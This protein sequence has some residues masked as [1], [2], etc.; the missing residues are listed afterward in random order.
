MDVLRRSNVPGPA[1]VGAGDDE[2][3]GDG[4]LEMDGGTSSERVDVIGNVPVGD[5]EYGVV[6]FGLNEK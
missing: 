2:R 1:V 3:N 4:V 5:D 6:A